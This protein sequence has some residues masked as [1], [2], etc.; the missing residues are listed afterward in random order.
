MAQQRAH[1]PT[2]RGGGI[3]SVLDIVQEIVDREHKYHTT[4]YDGVVG[5]TD[6]DKQLLLAKIREERIDE[7]VEV[8]KHMGIDEHNHYKDQRLYAW[9]WEERYPNLTRSKRSE[10]LRRLQTTPG[11]RLDVPEDS[12]QVRGDTPGGVPCFKGDYPLKPSK[13]IDTIKSLC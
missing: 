5:F 3:L 9:I 7:L 2:V 13:Q 6:K 12:R 10:P 4:D 8:T 1:R 11:K